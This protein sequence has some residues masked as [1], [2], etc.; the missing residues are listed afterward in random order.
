MTAACRWGVDLLLIQANPCIQA[1]LDMFQFAFTWA[2]DQMSRSFSS[3]R[4]SS[5]YPWYIAGGKLSDKI[6]EQRLK[7]KLSADICKR[8]SETL[9][10]ITLAYGEYVMTKSS[11]SEWHRRLKKRERMCASWPKKWAA[12]NTRHICK[13]WQGTNLGALRSKTGVRLIAEEDYRNLF[14]GKDPKSGL[15]SGF[16]TMTIS[17]RMIR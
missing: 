13:F 1:H 12:K 17:L 6:L 10:T 9:A 7:I 14:G 2:A 5:T 15:T 8:A 3:I 16:S 4:G 11:V